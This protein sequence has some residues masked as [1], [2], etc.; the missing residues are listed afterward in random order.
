MPLRAGPVPL[1]GVLFL[2]AGCDF[3]RPRTWQATG[4]NDA[5][6]RAMLAEP[7][8]AVRGVAA[9]TERAQPASQAV[10]RMEQDRRRPMPDSRAALIGTAATA[11]AAPEPM[12]GR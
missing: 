3:D 11:A 6:L 4:V 5:N 1:L 2:L 7:A 8:D 9:R 12:H 10:N